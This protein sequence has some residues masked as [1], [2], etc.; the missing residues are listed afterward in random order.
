[1]RLYSISGWHGDSENNG[2]VIDFS[3][4]ILFTTAA[5]IFKTN[6]MM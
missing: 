1:M 2:V 4:T 5:N 6:V 3:F